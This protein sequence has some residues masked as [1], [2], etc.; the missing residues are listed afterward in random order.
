MTPQ[1]T[2]DKLNWHL[3]QFWSLAKN[4][5]GG[6]VVK[7]ATFTNSGRPLIILSTETPPS[8]KKAK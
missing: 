1:E 6:F 2:L 8:V 7:G 4:A 3:N 5:G